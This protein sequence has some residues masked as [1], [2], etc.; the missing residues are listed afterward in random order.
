METL[1]FDPDDVAGMVMFAEV[2]RQ[3]SFTRAAAVLG[4]SKSAVSARVARLEQGLGARLLYRTSR[5]VDLTTAGSAL[6]PICLRVAEAAA[7]AR[8]VSLHAAQEPRGRL[9]LNAPVS[10]SQ[11]WLAVPLANFVANFPLLELE[12]TLQDDKVD[13][14][15]GGW[16]VVVRLGRV[17]DAALTVRRF[18]VDRLVC[19]ASPAYLRRRGEPR[20][21]AELSVHSC[22]RYTKAGP[23][24]EWSFDEYGGPAAIVVGGPVASTD[25]GLLV[26]LGE[27]G[28]GVVRAPWFL[29]AD[30]VRAGRLHRVLAD[31]PCGDLPCQVV[32]AH[33]RRPPAGVRAL[34]DHLVESFRVPPW[35]EPT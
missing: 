23:D 33:G 28:A 16:D 17:Q 20:R 7:D 24:R 30:A 25:G 22:L 21:P 32:H 10:F 12:I 2:A 11:R 1:P 31:Y 15:G 27:A 14:V 29:V 5:R 35:G 19:V 18:A 6:L 8:A 34:L 9:R 4:M 3:R 13:L 26:A